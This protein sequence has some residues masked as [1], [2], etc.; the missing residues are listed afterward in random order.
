MVTKMAQTRFGSGWKA[1]AGPVF[2]AGMF[3]LTAAPAGATAAVAPAESESDAAAVGADYTVYTGGFKAAE[4]TVTTRDNGYSGEP[5][6]CSV[7]MAPRSGMRQT[8]F[9]RMP[10]Q[11]DNAHMWLA[12]V[13]GGSVYIPVRT[14][15]RTPIGGTV[16]DVVKLRQYTAT[17]MAALPAAAK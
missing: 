1:I 3:T 16:M 14:Q 17:E 4:G 5:I 2:A 6:R 15:V 12:P 10:Q 9:V 13:N 8:S 7:Q 11:R